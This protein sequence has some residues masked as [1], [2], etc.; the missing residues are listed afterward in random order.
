MASIG[1]FKKTGDEYY[2][3]IFTLELQVTGVRF[4]PVTGRGGDNPPSHLIYV[5]R[6]E[7][8]VAWP[9]KTNDGRAYLSVKL[10]D[11]SLSAPINANLYKDEMGEDHTLIWS[12]PKPPKA[13][14]T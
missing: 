13:V 1:A 9:Q 14:R 7:I 10:D 4:T 8:G 11:A 3:E 5:G 2:G 6:V 12:R